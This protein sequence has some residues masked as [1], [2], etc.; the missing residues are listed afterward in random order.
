MKSIFTGLILTL[1]ITWN[2]SAQLT[3]G[4]YVLGGS[5]GVSF[6]KSPHEVYNLQRTSFSVTPNFGKFISKKYLLEGGLGYTFQRNNNQFG[7]GN[8]SRQTSHFFSV[9]FGAT[10]F[11]PIVDELYFTLGATVIPAY[12]ISRSESESEGVIM[13][14]R[15][16]MISA[17]LNIAPGLTYFINKKWMLYTYVGVLNYEI[18]HNSSTN[19]TGHNF[20]ANVSANSF[21]V[22]ARYILGEKTKAN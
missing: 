1:F 3:E 20:Y 18:T 8:F 22:G 21:G 16:N 9:R 5:A 14:D 15:S 2:S 6:S 13:E 19:L 10:R 4:S 7:F 17:R 12:V 11:F